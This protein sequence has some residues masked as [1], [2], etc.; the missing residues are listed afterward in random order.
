VRL[1][2]SGI[3]CPVKKAAR[4]NRSLSTGRKRVRKRYRSGYIGLAFVLASAIGMLAQSDRL[5]VQTK[6]GSQASDA[7]QLLLTARNEAPAIG[8]ESELPD[9][10]SSAKADASNADPVAS[11]VVKRESHGAPP[12][13]IGGPLSPDRSVADRNYWLVNGGMVGASIANVELTVRCLEV[14]A[15]CNDVP[16]SLKSRAALYG[17]G[18]PA[19]LGVAYLSYFMKKKHS[20][21]WYAAPAVV[22][23][24]NMFLA[25]RAYRWTNDK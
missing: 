25:V 11:P 23:G 15:S 18:I 16:S 19:D 2:P 13:A 17:I 10:P 4:E 9:A 1:R 20:R 3:C 8:N 22:T 24:A 14:H 21:I 6:D 12:A 5:E 7:G